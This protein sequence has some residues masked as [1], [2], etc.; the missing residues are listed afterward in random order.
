MGC[1]Q[2]PKHYAGGLKNQGIHRGGHHPREIRLIDAQFK[3]CTST[4]IICRK[5]LEPGRCPGGEHAKIPDH[6]AK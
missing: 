1:I 2:L 6:E 4:T 3:S 5:E